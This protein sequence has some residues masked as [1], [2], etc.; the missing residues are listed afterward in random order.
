[1]PED[2]NERKQT[3]EITSEG[4]ERVYVEQKDII[5]INMENLE[6]ILNSGSFELADNFET[7]LDGNIVMTGGIYEDT[8]ISGEYTSSGEDINLQVNGLEN[9]VIINMTPE[10]KVENIVLITTEENSASAAT[11]TVAMQNGE[12]TTLGIYMGTIRIPAENTVDNK[13]LTISTDKSISQFIIKYN[14]NGKVE[15]LKDLS[16]LGEGI[17]ASSIAMKNLGDKLTITYEYNKEQLI[18]PA[19]ETVTG[20][21][22]IVNNEKGSI[23]INLDE[24]LKV[25]NATSGISMSSGAAPSS[26]ESDGY[27]IESLS[28]GGMIIG[29]CNEY[30]ETTIPGDL[31]TSGEPIYIN[32]L[33]DGL[34][35]KYD[36]NLK[37]EWVTELGSQNGG[38]YVEISEVS[39]G[40]VAVV[41]YQGNLVIPAEDTEYG[42]A[43]SIENSEDAMQEALVKYTTDGK[44]EWAI[45]LDNN[46]DFDD[47][48]TIKETSNGYSIIDMNKG[49]IVSFEKIHEDPI[50]KEQAIVTITNTISKGSLVVHHYK[51]GTTESLSDDE[52]SIG[53]IGT[54]YATSP[55]N[56][57]PANYE[58]VATPENAT[59]TYAEGETI[60]TYYYRLK[61]P[62]I[63]NQNITKT[64]TASIDSFD[65]E[66]TY[67][68]S[69][70]AELADYT[71]D[72][73]VKL[74]DTLPYPLD[75][76]KTNVEEDLDGGTY[77]EAS[78]TITWDI[79]VEG[80]QATELKEIIVNKTI[81]VVYKNN[82]C[83]K[84]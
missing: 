76:T 1:M 72:V 25:I 62:N 69:Y 50:P 54:E 24:D 49:I 80:I 28:S 60:V 36:A 3:I 47:D 64:G 22:I 81:K 66:I 15:S 68:I 23:I 34:I 26:I 38:T 43:I 51:E 61:T 18:I 73:T 67:N 29:M 65:Q 16:Y 42:E 7:T 5:P 63:T 20:E 33:N 84:H 6:N 77:D 21:E 27:C 4:Y 52:T 19:S 11:N 12:Y 32:N 13:E 46:M 39:D 31:T 17:D 44:V 2:E 79:P 78:K 59:G 55:A 74:V 75:T 40:C 57:I 37:I 8:T 71:G 58:L 41:Y 10:G 35:L 83:I 9:G 48:C 45:E 82:R 70:T 56:D 30:G 53:D 14:S